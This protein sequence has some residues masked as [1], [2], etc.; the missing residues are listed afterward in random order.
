MIKCADYNIGDDLT[1]QLNATL[2]D[3]ITE[4][5]TYKLVFTDSLSDGLTFNSDSV[6]LLVDGTEI[7]NANGT[8]TAFPD[9]VLNISGQTMTVTIDDV[10]A[11]T[12]AEAGKVVSVQYTAKLNE[13]AVLGTT[14]E[15]NKAQ[16]EYSNNPN[17]GGQGTGKTTETEVK[18]Y[19]FG[20][21]LT[22]VVTY[23]PKD[24]AA[25][26]ETLAGA[27]FTL[28]NSDGKFVVVN[29]ENKVTGWAETADEGS[30]LTS[31]ADG[32]VKVEGLDAGTYTLTEETAPVGYN[33]LAAPITLVI[34]STIE[35]GVLKD[36]SATQNNEKTNVDDSKAIVSFD[37]MNSAGA[38]LPSTGGI[39][40]TIFYAAGIILMA[41][42]VFFVVRRKRA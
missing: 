10:K 17:N 24:P 36:M 39:G 15:N 26:R 4:Y 20:L 40:T 9:G 13:S 22:K 7:Y 30:K 14:G 42:A 3:A 18:V 19:T 6:K 37:V 33:K 11:I 34:N 35:D 12:G 16:L 5:Q 25:V 21:E 8:G 41:G 23:D 2:P 38:T 32:L 1:F 31:G 27:V 28:Q 29:A